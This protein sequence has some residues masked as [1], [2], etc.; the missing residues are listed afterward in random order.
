MRNLNSQPNFVSAHARNTRTHARTQNMQVFGCILEDFWHQEEARGG[1]LARGHSLEICS[2]RIEGANGPQ[3][4]CGHK[5]HLAQ[6]QR[7]DRLADR[8]QR[9]ST[10][11]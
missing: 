8:R 3:C 7:W 2:E 11:G 1:V 10:L 5:P 9:C 4:S 6:G